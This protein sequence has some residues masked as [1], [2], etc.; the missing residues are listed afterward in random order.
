MFII[1]F[2]IAAIPLA[3]IEWKQVR[4]SKQRRKGVFTLG[5]EPYQTETPRF[6]A[7]AL[8]NIQWIVLLFCA[9][10]V[11]AIG[12]IL[13][14]DLF[15]PDPLLIPTSMQLSFLVSVPDTVRWIVFGIGLICVLG[16]ILYLLLV[17]IRRIDLANLILEGNVLRARVGKNEAGRIDLSRAYT[18]EEAGF[19]RRYLRKPS[20]AYLV[21]LLEQDGQRMGIAIPLVHLSATTLPK[22]SET[23]I[24]KAGDLTILIPNEKLSMIEQRITER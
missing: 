5:A 23:T 7:H 10:Y 21:H 6:L 24:G 14:I 18:R 13:L 9:I 11:N 19:T 12:L 2:F 17:M 22:I 8:Q 3:I 15:V 1:S 4:E 16:Y 20:V